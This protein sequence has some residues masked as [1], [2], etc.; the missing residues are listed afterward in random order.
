MVQPKTVVFFAKNRCFVLTPRLSLFTFKNHISMKTI[1]SL[2]SVLVLMLGCKDNPQTTTAS[3]V[4]PPPPPKIETPISLEADVKNVAFAKKTSQEI[5]GR[6]RSTI[7]K[8]SEIKIEGDEFTDFYDGKNI[9]IS[10]LSYSKDC[11]ITDC[12]QGP[13]DCFMVLHKTE[14]YCYFITKLTADEFQYTMVGGK[15]QSFKR[16]R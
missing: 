7:D 1:I 16:V 5:Q 15:A 6:W 8:K 9:G 2:F 13:K 4:P 12:K 14:S 11:Q 3:A 10:S